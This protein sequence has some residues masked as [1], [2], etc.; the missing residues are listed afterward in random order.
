MKRIPSHQP[1]LGNNAV[2]SNGNWSDRYFN[3]WLARSNRTCRINACHYA[4]VYFYILIYGFPDAGVALISQVSVRQDIKFARRAFRMGI[5]SVTLASLIS[6][7][8]LTQVGTILN[9]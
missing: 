4:T 9:F 1:P 2:H 3:D 7:S 6:I 5:W 8:V